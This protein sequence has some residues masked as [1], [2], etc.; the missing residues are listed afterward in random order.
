MAEQ[1]ETRATPAHR[2]GHRIMG[3]VAC[4]RTGETQQ[5]FA[6]QRPRQFHPATSWDQ[7]RRR[8][9]PRSRFEAS[10]GTPA[11]RA[12]TVR[13]SAVAGARGLS[14]ICDLGPSGSC[15]PDISV[16]AQLISRRH[17]GSGARRDATD[18][19]E[20]R[21]RRRG[22]DGASSGRGARRWPLAGLCRRRP[23]GTPHAAVAHVVGR[24][25]RRAAPRSSARATGRDRCVLGLP[26]ESP[27]A[28][29]Q[30]RAWQRARSRRSSCRGAEPRAPAHRKLSIDNTTSTA[31]AT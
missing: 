30:T 27:V 18:A 11:M 29:E 23:A 5:A 1:R 26:G 15:R 19:L 3:A 4:P 8:A 9:L 10:R 31:R 12:R 28:F 2:P 13:R 21:C 14:H 17:T 20:R 25:R 16:P 24:R 6:F 22:G 7:R